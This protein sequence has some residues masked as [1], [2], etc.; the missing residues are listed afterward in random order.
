[1]I[2]VNK[3]CTRKSKLK[4]SYIFCMTKTCSL[5]FIDRLDS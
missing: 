4:L 1:M 2:K 3:R 5:S